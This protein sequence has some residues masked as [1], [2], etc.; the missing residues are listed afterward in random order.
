MTQTLT[1]VVKQAGDS[2]IGWIE[3]VPGAHCQEAMREELL[4]TL[5]EPLAGRLSS[6]IGG[7]L[8]TPLVRATRTFRLP[9]EAPCPAGASHRPWWHGAAQWR[10]PL[11]VA[12]PALNKRSTVPWYTGINTQLAQQDLS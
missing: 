4:E 2:W 5:R 7:K 6:S 12:Q 3:E 9:Y 8:V 11:M 1:A 10:A